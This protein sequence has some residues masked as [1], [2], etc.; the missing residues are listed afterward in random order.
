MY[1]SLLTLTTLLSFLSSISALD[2]WHLDETAI[3]VNEQLDPI[4]N[5]NSQSS[6]M[7]K[8]MGGSAFGASYNYDTYSK[9]KCT[10]LKLTADKSNYWMPSEYCLWQISDLS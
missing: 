7:H 6:H 1:P 4:I 8:V 3:L 2:A 9:A 10:S 5:P